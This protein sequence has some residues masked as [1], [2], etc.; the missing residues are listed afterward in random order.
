MDGAGRAGRFGWSKVI[1]EQWWVQRRTAGEGCRAGLRSRE[2]ARVEHDP[3]ASA[4]S[5]AACSAPAYQTAPQT[6]LQLAVQLNSPHLRLPRPSP[7]AVAPPC[8]TAP[9]NPDAAC[10]L[11]RPLTCVCRIL[12]RLQT[13]NIRSIRTA[14]LKP[15]RPCRCHPAIAPA[16]DASFTACSA[17]SRR[18][19]SLEVSLACKGASAIQLAQQ[20]NNRAC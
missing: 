14:P 1:L 16:S 8:Q 7:P 10:S 12:H 3:P 15:T 20:L 19:R 2:R 11:Q 13:C 6:H 18:L 9:Q 17:A 5:L 4:A